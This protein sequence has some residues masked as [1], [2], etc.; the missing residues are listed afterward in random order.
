LLN[1]SVGF[2]HTYV[3]AVSKI[4]PSFIVDIKFSNQDGLS[5]GNTADN[6]LGFRNIVKELWL[7]N[8]IE[9]SETDIISN[10]IEHISGLNGGIP[11][12]LILASLPRVDVESFIMDLN[13]VEKTFLA[14]KVI[15]DNYPYIAG[16][17]I[18]GVSNGL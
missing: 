10:H 9:F 18:Y 15:V 5:I 16:K 2:Y 3:A 8:G 4:K 1:N 7:S 17:L 14:L 12:I 11:C 6:H 13:V